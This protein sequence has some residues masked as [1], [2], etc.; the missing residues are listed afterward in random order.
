MTC[1]HCKGELEYDAV[2][3][4]CEICMMSAVSASDKSAEQSVLRWL[5]RVDEKD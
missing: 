1:K 4:F 3:P 2:T 5:A